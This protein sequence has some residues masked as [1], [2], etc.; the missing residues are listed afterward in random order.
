V[1]GIVKKPGKEGV[2]A[3]IS[4]GKKKKTIGPCPSGGGGTAEVPEPGTWW[5][6]VSGLAFVYWATRRRVASTAAH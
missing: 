5:L 4:D 3:V 1:C 2:V 6:L